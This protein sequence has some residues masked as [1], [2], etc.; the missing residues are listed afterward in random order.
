M[1]SDKED[2]TGRSDQYRSVR[3]WY[4]DEHPEH[5]V[6]LAAFYMDRYETTNAQYRAFVAATGHRPPQNWIENGYIF[7]MKQA[8]VTALET[9][10][11]RGL[12]ANVFRLDMDTTVLSKQQLLDAIVQRWTD[13]DALPVTFVDWYDAKA[14]CEWKGKR[15]PTEAEWEKAA[16]GANGNDFP[17][18][19]V[20]Q[21]GMNNTGDKAWEDGAAPVGSYS[22]D[23]SPFRIMD[24]S[25]NVAEWVEDW[26]QPYPGSD[27]ESADFGKKYR[28]VRGAGFQVGGHYALTYFQ[29][30]AYR[31]FLQP[32]ATN[33]D[34]GIRCAKDAY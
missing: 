1:G 2:E 3:P 12:V 7:R 27:Y 4:L 5:K 23:Q 18:G 34:V 28:V 11:L 19:N 9:P 33:A 14:Y 25:G 15:L 13:L 21:A 17:W 22:G 30:G 16:R 20:W 8:R 32:E 6:D 31:F 26:Y 10:Q 29:R 24:M